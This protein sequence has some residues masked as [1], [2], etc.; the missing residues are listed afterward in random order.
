MYIKKSDAARLYK[1]VRIMKHD[2]QILT[3]MSREEIR[4]I[5]FV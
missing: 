2:T 5:L 3:I 1:F 4:C